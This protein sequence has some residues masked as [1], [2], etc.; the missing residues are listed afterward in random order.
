MKGVCDPTSRD[1]RLPIKTAQ[2]PTGLYQLEKY[3]RLGTLKAEAV[4]GHHHHHHASTGSVLKW[5]TALTSA[6][7]VLEVV[8]GMRAH[9]LALLSDAGHNFTDALALLLALFG[10]YWQH[11]PPSESKTYGYQRAGVLAA[12]VNALT[13]IPLSLWLF[14][15][16][17]VRLRHPE[18][19]AEGTMIWV[20]AIAL[21]VNGG[22][23]WALH[24]EGSEHD[25][26]IRAAAVH[27]LGDALGSVA[28]I[29]GA[30][31]IRYTGWLQIDPILSILL[32]VLIVW[33]SWDIIKDSLNV[34]LEGLPR[35]LRLPEVAAA[36]RAVPGVNHVHDVHIWSLG[37]E[38]AALS[39]HVAIDDMSVSASSDI[40]R[41]INRVLAEKFRIQHTTV[42]IEHGECHLSHHNCSMV[43]VQHHHH[44]C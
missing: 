29:V 34:L 24:R 38:T 44:G 1:T 2:I 32:S 13:L 17:V 3:F 15:E 35:G 36:M 21:A 43:E 26:N 31:V 19:V 6:F 37:S 22:I 14:Y 11:K 4:V 40:L 25:L 41:E 7:V 9:S 23:L 28:I 12:F 42:Q 39:C 33:T 18:P 20:A 8:M 5:S 10:F 16:S 30:V 27:M